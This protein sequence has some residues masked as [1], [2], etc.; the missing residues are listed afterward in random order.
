M[1]D[2]GRAPGAYVVDVLVAVNVPRLGALNTVKDNWLATNRFEGPNG[3]GDTT[4]H[5]LSRL[6]HQLIRHLSLEGGPRL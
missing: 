2:D 6:G 5:D 1:A 3:R 4:R